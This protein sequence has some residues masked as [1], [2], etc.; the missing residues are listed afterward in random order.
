[1][2]PDDRSRLRRI[3]EAIEPKAM[4]FTLS[5]QQENE[6]LAATEEIERG[7]FVTLDQVLESIRK[8][9]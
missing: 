4:P 8:Y 2:S 1:M 3:V 5:E 7:D 6:L 9:G